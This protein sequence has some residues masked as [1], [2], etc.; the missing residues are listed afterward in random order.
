M[1]YDIMGTEL[2]HFEKN[3]RR[4]HVNYPPSKDNGFPPTTNER[5]LLMNMEEHY[6]KVISLFQS[7]LDTHK[8]IWVLKKHAEPIYYVMEAQDVNQEVFEELWLCKTPIELFDCFLNHMVTTYLNENVL[9]DPGYAED[10]DNTENERL[11]NVLTTDKREE[12]DNF[13]MKLKEKFALYIE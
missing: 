5:I 3:R 1:L 9:T 6:L 10:V 4:E 7:Y 11:Y 13:V 12:L 8:D 2:F